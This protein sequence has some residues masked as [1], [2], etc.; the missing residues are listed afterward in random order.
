MSRHVGQVAALYRYP[1][2][3]M[4]GEPLHQA[5]VSWHGVAGDRRWAFVRDG[6]ARSGFPWLTMRERSDM[7]Q[8]RPAFSEPDRPDASATVV[9]TPAGDEFDVID[10]ALAAELGH[11]ARVI[12]QDR[13]VFDTAPLSLIT[14]QTVAAI[15]GMVGAELARRL[16]GAVDS[17]AVQTAMLLVSEVVTNAVTHGTLS[18]SGTLDVEVDVCGDRFWIGV[19]NSGPAFDHVPVLPA[20]DDTNGRGLF[21]VDALARDWGTGHARGTTSVWFELDSRPAVAA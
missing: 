3:S 16:A 2:K 13:G 9:R 8:Y 14:T 1:V 4:G 12:K 10:P 15:G 20:A 17:T 18:G 21:V 7:G 19:S 11:G 5:D 6:L